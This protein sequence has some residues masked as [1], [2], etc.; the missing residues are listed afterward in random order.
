MLT[1]LYQHHI[2][3]SNQ[4]V[5]NGTYACTATLHQIYPEITSLVSLTPNTHSVV[6]DSD[7]LCL[8]CECARSTGKHK[9][10]I[11]AFMSNIRVEFG[12]QEGDHCD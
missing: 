10:C 1:Q 9:W 8:N 5:R 11:S 4:I 6:C 3:W 7:Q 12:R 2:F